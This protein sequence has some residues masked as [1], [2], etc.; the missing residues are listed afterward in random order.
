[1]TVGTDRAVKEQALSC[2]PATY[3][4]RGSEDW[5]ALYQ[6]SFPTG[7]VIHPADDAQAI[8]TCRCVDPLD[9]PKC[10]T[11]GSS[12][13]ENDKLLCHAEIWGSGWWRAEIAIA[14]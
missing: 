13:S 4:L 8:R 3:L 1:M 11:A 5:Q 6:F 2:L 9:Y 14:A 12:C 10:L 7:V